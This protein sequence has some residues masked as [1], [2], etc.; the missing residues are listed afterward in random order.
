VCVEPYTKNTR[1][2][3]ECAKCQYTSCRLCC[4][5]YILGTINEAHCM[6]CK[7]PWDRSFL[8]NNFTYKFVNE[9]YKKFLGNL[10]F[11]REKANMEPAYAVLETY[12]EVYTLE[13]EVVNI[14]KEINDI[15][16]QMKELQCRKNIIIDRR[17]VINSSIKT[18]EN[19]GTVK[20]QKFFGHCP[21]DYCKGLVSSGSR[22]NVCDQ[23]VCMSCK[24]KSDDTHVCK[25]E[26]LESLKAIKKDS[27][28]CPK[29]KVYIHK[30]EGCNQMFCTNCNISFCW[31]TG[32][33]YRGK[34][35]HNPHY[36]QWR[37]GGGGVEQCND[38]LLELFIFGFRTYYGISPEVLNIYNTVLQFIDTTRRVLPM[39]REKTTNKNKTRKYKVDYL[40]GL[41]D[42]TRLKKLLQEE[43][44]KLQMTNEKIT[45]LESITSSASVIITS[46]FGEKLTHKITTCE[47]NEFYKGMEDLVRFS[48]T[49]KDEYRKKYKGVCYV[50]NW[51]Y[52]MST[53]CSYVGIAIG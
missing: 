29:C 45:I 14:R 26:T 1:K 53:N 41:I 3:I 8:V 21:T 27:K 33:I 6:N 4:Q 7:N 36:F 50:L 19:K 15:D 28:P 47:Y 16:N 12:R 20:C 17:N 11:D 24:E 52:K 37:E 44:L 9:D 18:L 38:N 49:L 43:D 51:T 25:P 5:Q 34:N 22:C 2:E 32:E 10:L 42:D 30:T 35:I 39:L 13:K 48:K 31:R 40:L 23:R 46:I